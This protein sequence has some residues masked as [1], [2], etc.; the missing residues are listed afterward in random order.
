MD[1]SNNSNN[2]GRLLKL[3]FACLTF[4]VTPFALA[5]Q[6][7]LNFSDI[8]NGPKTGLGDGLGEG[9][10]VT[11]WGNNLGND[12]GDSKIYV[13]GHEA[14]H[15]YYWGKADGSKSAGPAD[16][17][18]YH[19]MQ[20]IAFSVPS[21]VEDGLTNI[22]VE[23]NG[24]VSNTLPF[25][26]RAGKI[27]FVKT[28]G[29]NTNGDG[30]W[31]NPW[32]TLDYAGEGA[33]RR[34]A[35]GDIIYA[36]DGV[37]KAGGL[38][39][40]YLKGTAENPF[41][42]IA[43][44]GAEV[45]IHGET[46]FGIANHVA[47]STHWHFAKLK[48][49]TTG[50]GIGT[51][52]GMRA[53]ANEISNYPGGCANGQSGAISGASM[54]KGTSSGIKAFGNYI[55][56]FGCDTTSKLHHVFYISNRGGTA[57]E[58]FE[59]GWNYLRDNKAHHAL[60]I[61]DEGICGDFTGTIRV[62]NNVVINQVGVAAGISSGAYDP[63]CFTMPVEIYNN[64][65]VNVGQEIPT[66]SGHNNAIS[67]M[68]KETVS[69]VKIY[70][71]TLV[72]Y[73]EPGAGYALQ[74]QDHGH[75]DWNFGGTWEF[76][77]NIVVDT[78]DR[79]YESASYWKA[80]DV[81]GNNLWFNGGDGVPA[82]PPSWDASPLSSDPKFVDSTALRFDLTETSE[83][84]SGGRDLKPTVMLDMKGIPR[85]ASPSIGALQ[86]HDQSLPAP[87]KAIDSLQVE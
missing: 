14:A 46:G 9:A 6:P 5:A 40:R 53:V 23:V 70:N 16:L 34:L 28:T 68:R 21:N 51:F 35:P 78:H 10:I 25:T 4:V 57:L 39:I 65:F 66:C 15:V 86:Y 48:V 64:L 62:H 29:D 59:L 42:I 49:T 33:G 58:A 20:T 74:V 83:A 43:Y 56:D 77:N 2:K 32:K 30:S 31:A 54:G 52:E 61:F 37:T 55:H 63:P 87:P 73:G 44:P 71:N 45:V 24:A 79:P 67:L 82:A 60:H 75:T 12:Q 11:V 13:G 80:A 41:A 84:K 72:G 19:N 26:V 7:V 27:V 8:V 38:S 22:Q 47:D 81:S 36:T 85:T 3:V 69:H 76:V 17:H 18:S 50:T 1:S